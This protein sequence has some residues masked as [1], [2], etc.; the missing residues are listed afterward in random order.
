MKKLFSVL[1]AVVL[2]LSLSVTAFAATKYKT[3]A[4]IV[5]GLTDRPV[6]EVI[7]E[8]IETGK[9]YGTIAKD[10]GKL[11]E[12][13]TEV[14]KLKESHLDEMVKDGRMTRSEA[15]EVLKY[16][17]DHQEICVG[18]GCIYGHGAYQGAGLANRDENRA[19]RYNAED[20]EYYGYGMGYGHHRGGMGYGMGRGGCCGYRY[21]Q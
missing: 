6:E 16:I 14:Y 19:Y 8:R 1:I 12:F 4:E 21:N 10:A 17:K 13:K 7:D 18:E 15:D 20:G 5:A 9:T 2:V 3:P 11:E